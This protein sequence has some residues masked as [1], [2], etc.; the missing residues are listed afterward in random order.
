MTFYLL[1]I[2]YKI[3]N[4][5]DIKVFKNKHIQTD[6][7]IVTDNKTSQTE[8]IIVPLIVNNFTQTDIKLSD[9]YE[10]NEWSNLTWIKTDTIDLV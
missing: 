7:R 4:L 6:S 10:D 3:Y 5:F 8:V 1:Q 2:F 9:I